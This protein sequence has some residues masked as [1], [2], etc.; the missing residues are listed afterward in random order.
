MTH[1]T[2]QS[3]C[4]V[5]TIYDM[6]APLVADIASQAETLKESQA[7]S[8]RRFSPEIHGVRGLALTLVV[9]FHLFGQ[10]R[11][12][13][14]V[15]VFLVVSAY[16]LTG[17]LDRAFA[18]QSAPSA[19]NPSAR[20]SLVNRYGRTFS[21]LVPASLLTIV[22]T[23]LAGW[24]VL[25][26][27]KMSDLLEQASA[28]ALFYENYF[29][30]TKGRSYEA[31]G[32]GTS[33]FQHFWSLSVQAQFLILWPLAALLLFLG[34]RAIG[35]TWSTT[36]YLALTVLMTAVSFAHAAWLVGEEQTVAYYS[37]LARLWEFGLGAIAALVVSRIPRSLKSVGILGWVGVA[38]IL[39]S[40]FL[41]DGRDLFPGPWTLLPTIGAVLVLFS[42]DSGASEQSGLAG[43]L[44]LKPIAGLANLGYTLYLWHWPM[45][46]L[47]LE[48]HGLDRAGWKGSIV[49]LALSLAL[50]ATTNRFVSKPFATWA[51]KAQSTQAGAWR[52]LI[53]ILFAVAVV[54][55]AAWSG[56]LYEVNRAQREVATSAKPVYEHP[57]ARALFDPEQYPQSWEDAPIPAAD[58]AGVDYASI[59]EEGCIPDGDDDSFHVCPDL[60]GANATKVPNEERKTVVLAGAS[61]DVQYYDALRKVADIAGWELLVVARSGCR[62]TIEDPDV[63]VSKECLSWKERAFEAIADIKPDAVITM[64]TVT[65]TGEPDRFTDS[66]VRAWEFFEEQGIPV[67]ALRDNPRFP[68]DVPECIQT[69]EDPEVCGIARAD[70]YSEVFP[71]A[72]D[73]LP[74]NLIPIDTSH[75]F[76]PDDW[77]PAIIGNVV[78]YRDD[79]HLTQTFARTLAPF[80]LASLDEEAPFLFD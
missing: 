67:I 4:W 16:L 57:G 75:M 23:A 79:E 24:M 13:G 25:P 1:R 14:G 63:P 26:R 27:S 76:C 21:R 58:V 41:L 2:G 69:E 71:L 5:R 49:V 45:L 62:L 22:A 60:P 28:S 15:D 34:L 40:G 36:V 6:P 59:Y 30:A 19:S 51:S 68:H 66:Q 64:G 39:S 77:C 7:A 42:A 53:V 3:F 50:A 32:N 80:F 55:G 72:S 48:W 9:A 65:K 74:D 54:G 78:A 12:S 56:H 52:V 29:L 10:G 38:L 33:P 37:L 44:S 46:V 35:R 17:S 20:F 61:H 73:G 8:K 11:V 43:A 47:Y 31:A 70:V 18:K